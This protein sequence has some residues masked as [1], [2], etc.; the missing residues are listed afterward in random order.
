MKKQ[1]K[2]KIIVAVIATIVIVMAILLIVAL[3]PNAYGYNWFERNK[4]VID[5]GVGTVKFGAYQIQY[6]QY[7]N[8]YFSTTPTEANSLQLREASLEACAQEVLFIAKAEELGIELTADQKANVNAAGQAAID[9]LKNSIKTSLQN[10]GVAN[11]TDAQINQYLTDEFVDMGMSKSGYMKAAEF[12]QKAY[13]CSVNVSAY[14]QSEETCP[15]TEDQIK[16]EYDKIVEE[17]FSDY[18][19]GD[20]A[21]YESGYQAGNYSI[22]YLVIPEDFV[23]VRTIKVDNETDRDTIINGL[24]AGED[25]EQYLRKEI[26]TDEF[27]KTMELDE[28]YAIG[29]DD[30]FMKDDNQI[31]DKAVNMEIGA[32]DWV[33]VETTTTDD[34]GT[35]VVNHTYYIFMRVDGQTG[36]VPYEKYAS[37]IKSSII[38]GIMTDELMANVTYPNTSLLDSF[39]VAY[40]TFRDSVA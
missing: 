32:W 16:A 30:S 35:E 6:A 40:R 20:Y 25:F 4:T 9:S 38:S 12:S 2:K 21:L 39:D 10:R 36:K 27:I 18:Q 7:G 33:D 29:K 22:R 14:Y 37:G 3:Q 23:F 24:N 34:E 17:S 26:N 13:Y 15:Y 19:V 1:T 28:G 8:T 31:Y 5:T 11:P